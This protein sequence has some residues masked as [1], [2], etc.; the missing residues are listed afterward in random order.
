MAEERYVVMTVECPRCKTKQ[1]VHVAARTGFAQLGDQT[2]PCIR[3][4]THFKRMRHNFTFSHHATRVLGSP[5]CL[6]RVR[7]PMEK[8]LS[9][10]SFTLRWM[11][12]TL[13]QENRIAISSGKIQMNGRHVSSCKKNKQ[14]GAQDR[15]HITM[16]SYDVVTAGSK[17][18]RRHFT[19]DCCW[20][21]TPESSCL[22]EWHK[23]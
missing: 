5:R 22:C 19:T 8:V 17:H 12:R 9:H 11:P 4:N 13:T 7:S 18:I 6:C 3:C 21:L 2:I 23:T 15:Y 1:K 14:S 16:Y 20:F 10:S